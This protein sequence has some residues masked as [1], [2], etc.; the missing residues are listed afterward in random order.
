MSNSIA[1][2]VV[3]QST[4]MFP[5]RDREANLTFS[6]EGRGAADPRS[7]LRRRVRS[8]T[9]PPRQYSQ[10]GEGVSPHYRTNFG[11]PRPSLLSSAH[12]P[13]SI[14]IP[15]PYPPLF[16]DRAACLLTATRR[17]ATQR[18]DKGDGEKEGKG[19]EDAEGSE[20]KAESSILLYT[21]QP[22]SIND[23]SD[24]GGMLG[25]D[26]DTFQLVDPSQRTD[27]SYLD[28]SLSFQSFGRLHK[29]SVFLAIFISAVRVDSFLSPSD[30]SIDQTIK[31]TDERTIE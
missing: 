9:A 1:D 25:E 15:G 13:D 8:V 17:D 19:K 20:E 22:H 14:A 26:G 28:S 4:M 30:Q 12:P 5:S 31:P 21:T 10:L 3:A 24:D 2:M 6:E 18:A 11:A 16:A 29:L 27:A 23:D 7:H